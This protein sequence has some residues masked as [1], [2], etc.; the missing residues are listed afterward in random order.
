MKMATCAG[1]IASI[2]DDISFNHLQELTEDDVREVLHKVQR[3]DP[4]R[5]SCT[6]S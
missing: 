4:C 1:P 6:R 2:V 3:L 5:D